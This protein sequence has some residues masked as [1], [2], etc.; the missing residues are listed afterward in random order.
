M[1]STVEQSV[2]LLKEASATRAVPS[3][4][5]FQALLRLEKEKLPVSKKAVLCRRL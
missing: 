5:V 2:A 3:A 4:S 1:D